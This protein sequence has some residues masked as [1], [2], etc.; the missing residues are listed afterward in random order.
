VF[1]EPDNVSVTKMDVS[2]LAMV[3]APNCL[4]CQSTD[5]LVVFE[6][7]RKEMSFMRLLIDN[8]D[9]KSIDTVLPTCPCCQRKR[10]L[11]T[12]RLSR[13]DENALMF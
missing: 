13:D 8:L 6:N 9:T 5:P 11:V 10:L 3:W 7:A 2:N 1:V 12:R 4:R